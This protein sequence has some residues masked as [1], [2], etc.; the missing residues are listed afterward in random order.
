MAHTQLFH[1]L[2]RA[3]TL[4]WLTERSG[5]ETEEYVGR[6][7]EHWQT[8]RQ[9]LK[10]AVGTAVLS[11]AP[12][13]SVGCDS[14]R[15]PVVQRPPSDVRIAVV[16]AGLAGLHC[17]YRLQQAGIPT[18]V[19]EAST[20][21]GGRMLSVRGLLADGYV[22]E[23]GGEFINSDH[24][25]IHVLTAELDVAL[26]DLSPT[27]DAIHLGGRFVSEEEIV[28]SFR[29]VAAMMHQTVMTAKTDRKAFVR[30]D[31]MNI[32]Q[33]L[34]E[35]AHAEPLI[36]DLLIAAYTA[37]YGLDA[38]EQSVFNLLESIDYTTL[39]PFRI[40]GDSDERY[41]VHAGNDTLTTRLAEALEGRIQFGMHLVAVI[42]RAN[43]TY[44]LIFERHRT[45]IEH[46]CDQVVFA[47]PFT[48]LREVEIQVALP[49]AKRRVIDELGYGTNAKLLG[50][51]TSRVWRE[52]YHYRG[53]VI[54]DN[55]LQ[56]IWDASW[57]QPGVA[58]LLTNF[59]GG[60]A[61][62]QMGIGTAEARMQLALVRL[63]RLFPGTSTAYL[64]G[65]AFRMHWPTAPFAK[66][67]YACY[68]PGQRRFYGIEGHRVRNLHFC[69]EHCSLDFQGYMEGACET[70]AKVAAEILA[71]LGMS[72]PHG[73]LQGLRY[74]NMSQ[75]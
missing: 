72:P 27:N 45:T 24:T 10:T 12:L 43:G 68:R 51:F 38:E 71:D 57:G 33:W 11:P 70:G 17:A 5:L 22:A 40:F 7:R 36:R 16:G 58:G 53:D 67:S 41:R 21:V 9:F 35:V 3:L 8:R 62:L 54:T 1:A 60:R 52:R 65:S 13:M 39:H 48:M 19:F 2:K 69:G 25:A 30:I 6:T 44:R 23:L 63:D 75:H 18:R 26:E 74:A 42:E 50:G 56:T 32:V 29:P 34:D 64:P 31:N 4:A 46:V 47:I 66:G 37:E 20:G 73:I 28:A 59:V 55:G 49:P 61:G 14:K 15:T